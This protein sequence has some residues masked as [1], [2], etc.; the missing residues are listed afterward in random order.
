MK[1]SFRN[2]I[3]ICNLNTSNL[4]CIIKNLV[5]VLHS[6]VKNFNPRVIN[7]ENEIAKRD[8]EDLQRTT[9]LHFSHP[10]QLTHC[11][12]SPMTELGEE[13]FEEIWESSELKFMACKRE[14]Q[15]TLTFI[16]LPCQFVIHE[17]CMN[18]MSMQVQ[19][20][21]FHPHQ[22]LHPRPFF[23]ARGQIRCYACRKKVNGF[24]FYYNECDVDL[25]VSCTKYQTRAT[26]H[27]CH[28]HNLLQL[29]KSIIVEISYHDCGHKNC[30]DSIFSCRNCDFNVL[31]PSEEILLD[32]RRIE[33][34]FDDG[35]VK[36]YVVVH[37]IA[38]NFVH[39]TSTAN[40]LLQ[41]MKPQKQGIS[42]PLS[43]IL[44]IAIKLH[45]ARSAFSKQSQT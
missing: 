45:G 33:E 32:P 4:E 40:V 3:Q 28:P 5:V 34:N 10:H 7:D 43:T 13:I 6:T 17:S 39:S 23:N 35:N 22:I 42:K 1:D 30:N 29:G 26:K 27:N 38:V 9:T 16:C 31:E 8:N 24:S 41:K 2:M 37:F 20:C 25:H 18:N 19:S 12:V 21:L 15:D 14:L 11:K 44:V 36:D